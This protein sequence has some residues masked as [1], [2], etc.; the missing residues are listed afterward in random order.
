MP[1]ATIKSV[2]SLRSRWWW[3]VAVSAV[4]LAAV[5]GSLF[6][7]LARSYA[8]QQVEARVR[9]VMLES[10]SLHW[11]VQHDMHPALYEAQAEGRIPPGFYAPE[12]LSSSYIARN[13]YEHYNELRREQGLPEIRY[14]LAAVDPRNN[15]N[16]ADAFE[17]SLIEL[18]REDRQRCEYRDVVK[19]D[20][21]SYLLYATPF[22]AVEE[23]CL[24]CHGAPEEAPQQLRERY[25]WTGGFNRKV[26]DVFA[27][28][29]VYS[30]LEGE[31]AQT[32]MMVVVFLAAVAVALI[33]FLGQSRLRQL[34]DQYTA[35]LRDSEERFRILFEQA[36]E[37]VVLVDPE[38]LRIVD[39]NDLAPRNSATRKRS[40]ERCGFRISKQ[41]KHPRR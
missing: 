31:F 3:I 5:A 28:E 38:T 17:E 30:P 32:N 10:R 9:D 20:G 6:Y 23:R 27:A 12:L 8:L 15:V 11:Y 25:R 26:G 18:F 2:G 22:L 7:H 40:S 29:V 39:F 19:M 35:V 41:P 13:M 36:A 4:A 34:V 21:K 24:K 16:R 14:K 1:A 33:F 37:S